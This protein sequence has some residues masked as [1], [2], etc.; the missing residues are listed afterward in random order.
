MIAETK[1][2]TVIVTTIDSTHHIYIAW[3][4]ALSC[5]V[6]T[7][8][9]MTTDLP[10]LQ[11]IFEA[12]GRTGRSLWV[13]FNYRYAPAYTQFRQLVMEGAVG[14]AFSRGLLLDA[15]HQSWGRLLPPLASRKTKQ[16]DGQVSAKGTVQAG[17]NACLSYV[18]R[19]IRC[20]CT[21]G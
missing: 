9:P 2:D 15:G 10:K 7:E 16:G 19:G 13:T 12:I 11:A 21:G 18:W 8:K 4:M 1:P 17:K 3:A 5:D 6:I 20:G 14:R